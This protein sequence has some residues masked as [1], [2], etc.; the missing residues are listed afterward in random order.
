MAMGISGVMTARLLA[1]GVALAGAALAGAARAEAA[2]ADVAVIAGNCANCHGPQGRSPGAIPGI[3][4]HPFTVLKATLLAY[5][6]DEIPGTTV[7]NRLA[8]GYSDAEIEAIARYFS[9][10][11]AEAS[12]K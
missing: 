11:P 7:M 10:I 1:A 9:S 8:K 3:A 4:G 2:E 12:P 5:K 6:T